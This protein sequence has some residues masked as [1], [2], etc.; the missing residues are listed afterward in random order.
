[1]QR[2]ILED[3]TKIFELLVLVLLIG[4]IATGGLMITGGLTGNLKN[5]LLGFIIGVAMIGASLVLLVS[6]IRS[7]RKDGEN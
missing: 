7:F 1:M 5:N 6:I 2:Q 3:M 4:V